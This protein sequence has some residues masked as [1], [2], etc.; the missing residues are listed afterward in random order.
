[1]TR[2][3]DYRKRALLAVL[4]IVLAALLAVSAAS[5]TRADAAVSAYCN[6]INMQS[7]SY[8]GNFCTGAARTMYQVMGWGD[9]RPVCISVGGPS[10]GHGI[11]Y[12]CSGSKGTG[13]YTPTFGPA[14]FNPMIST[15]G[16]GSNVVHGVVYQP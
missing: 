1:M 14:F 11:F 13:V 8:P 12:G 15:V 16:S 2:A 6:N 3:S 4:G 9:Q 5:A 7:P 10:G